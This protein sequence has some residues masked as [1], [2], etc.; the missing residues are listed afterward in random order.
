MKS[1]YFPTALLCLLLVLTGCSKSTLRSRTA[2]FSKYIVRQAGLTPEEKERVNKNCLKGM[3][4]KSPQAEFGP[5]ELVF[6]DGYVLEHSSIDK[7]PIWVC[8]GVSEEQLGGSLERSNKFRPDPLLKKGRAELADYKG[9]GYDR[10]HQA[11]AGNQT[12]DERLK[13]ETFYLSNMAP[14][15]PALNQKIWKALEDSSRDWVRKYGMAYE[16]TGG[17]FYD[18]AEEDA[19][20]ADGVINYFS[21]GPGNVAVPTHFYKIIVAKDSQGDLH[22]IAFVMENKKYNPPFELQKHIVSIRWIEE[23]TGLDFMPE[24]SPQDAEKLESNP[25]R[26]W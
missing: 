6:R 1:R 10:G 13:D 26:M 22:A 21:I 9:S 25:S 18:P 7:I 23:R 15:L 2:P 5:T 12:V 16:L 20:Q 8:E 3:P 17:F 11:P 4:R 14:Q 19:D 24:L